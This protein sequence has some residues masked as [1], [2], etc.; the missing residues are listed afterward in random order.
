MIAFNKNYCEMSEDQIP[1]DAVTVITIRT[2]PGANPKLAAERF[3]KLVFEK[4]D[5]AFDEIVHAT[6]YDEMVETLEAVFAMPTPQIL[7]ILTFPCGPEH[8]GAII[9]HMRPRA[10]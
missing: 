8:S 1:A 7:K 9:A 6:P 2:M 4:I 10:A 3:A 5:G